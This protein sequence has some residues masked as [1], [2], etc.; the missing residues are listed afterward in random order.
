MINDST[1]TKYEIQR[2]KKWP[3][4][5]QYILC[6]TFSLQQTYLIVIL[7]PVK[8]LLPYEQQILYHY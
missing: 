2:N 3:L 1:P 5:D 7:I 4:T 8:C 6:S